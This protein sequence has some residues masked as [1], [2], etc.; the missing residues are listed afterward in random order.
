LIAFKN[1]LEGTKDRVGLIALKDWGAVEVQTPT[2]NWTRLVAKLMTLRLS[3]YTPLAAGL[4][5]A[6]ETIKRERRR[7][8]GTLPL[9]V[10]FSDFLPNIQLRGL[11]TPDLGLPE[12]ITDVLHQCFLLAGDQIPLI[13]I[14][15]H[16]EFFKI[17]GRRHHNVILDWVHKRAHELDIPNYIEVGI[18][19]DK[20]VPFLAFYMAYITSGRTY[21]GDELT[22]PTE[23]ISEIHRIAQART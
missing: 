20:L 8:P 21:I 13:T 6:H 23:I 10:V 16:H 17:K 18:K 14:N 1:C 11:N 22:T 4:K 15:L 12:A 19:E 3:G 2:T 5:R 7:N 9:V